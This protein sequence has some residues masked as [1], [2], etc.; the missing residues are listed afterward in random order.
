MERKKPLTEAL[1]CNKLP[2]FSS[3]L[4][5]S[6]PKDKQKVASLK[7]DVQLF[8]RLY[9]ACQTREENLDDFFRHEN[10]LYLHPCPRQGSLE[11]E[12]RVIFCNALRK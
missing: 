2:L 5:K 12:Q 11:L 1:S 7:N 8:S 10:Q 3:S 9:I 6:Q 4:A